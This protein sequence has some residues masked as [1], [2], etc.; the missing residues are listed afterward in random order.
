MINIILI[1][2]VCWTLFSAFLPFTV[3]YFFHL[4]VDH[5]F[6]VQSINHIL[7]NFLQIHFL[8]HVMLRLW[9]LSKFFIQII[10]VEIF[11]ILVFQDFWISSVFVQVREF[12]MVLRYPTCLLEWTYYV[13]FLWVTLL[14]LDVLWDEPPI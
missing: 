14:I 1:I 2:P 4:S 13:I 5:V 7:I 6:I 9:A 10:S 8:F 12:I 3:K 11:Q